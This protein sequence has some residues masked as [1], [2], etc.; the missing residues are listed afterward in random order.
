MMAY[1]IKRDSKAPLVD[2]HPWVPTP[3]SRYR[4]ESWLLH[5]SWPLHH[6][7][8]Y[9][10]TLGFS[11]THTFFVSSPAGVAWGNSPARDDCYYSS[12]HAMVGGPALQVGNHFQSFQLPQLCALLRMSWFHPQNSVC[13]DPGI[14][15]LLGMHS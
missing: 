1:Q 7:N 15:R 14:C 11:I 2:V 9:I 13:T 12:Q 6:P 8:F 3:Y 5:H 10:I 4:L